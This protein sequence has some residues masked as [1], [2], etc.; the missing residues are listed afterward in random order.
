MEKG[1]LSSW[2]VAEDAAQVADIKVAGDDCMLAIGEEPEPLS[3]PPVG[4]STCFLAW[5]KNGYS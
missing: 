5:P 4:M 2:A 1:V 3:N